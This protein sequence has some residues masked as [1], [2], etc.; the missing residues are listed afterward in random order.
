LRTQ[1]GEYVER[2]DS[3][4][5]ETVKLHFVF[6]RKREHAAQ[7]TYDDLWSPYDTTSPGMAFTCGF[8]GGTAERIR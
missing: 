5:W 4:E 3:G 8:A 2:I 6:T 7:F 1:E